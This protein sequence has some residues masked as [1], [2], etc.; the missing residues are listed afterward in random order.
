MRGLRF[1]PLPANSPADPCTPPAQQRGYPGGR[2]RARRPGLPARKGGREGRRDCA[3]RWRGGCRGR[4]GLTAPRAEGPAPGQAV[5]RPSAPAG[6][7]RPT[8][9]DSAG[10]GR[11]C[12]APPAAARRDFA[13]ALDLSAALRWRAVGVP[14]CRTWVLPHGPAWPCL[15]AIRQGGRAD[16]DGASRAVRAVILRGGGKCPLAGFLC[17]QFEP[18]CALTPWM[19]RK[20]PN[21]WW[22][23][24][25]IQHGLWRSGR[26]R[27]IQV[28]PPINWTRQEGGGCRRRRI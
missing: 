3:S 26:H 19:Q 7:W 21:P 27:S 10:T 14:L 24:E 6:A 11:K 12:H 28:P 17:R 18:C 4:Q 20:F 2:R 15:R 1:L 22:P 13:A 9:S 8:E 23:A 16:S 25:F 5:P